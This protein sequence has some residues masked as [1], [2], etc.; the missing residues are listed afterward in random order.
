MARGAFRAIQRHGDVIRRI[1]FEHAFEH[2]R[3]TVHRIRRQTLAAR[4]TSDRK[5]GAI[6]LRHAIDD[7][8]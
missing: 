8:E 1:L 6:G 3:E 4:K 2:D 7:Q 5:V